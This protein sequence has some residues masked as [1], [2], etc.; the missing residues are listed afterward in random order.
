[1]PERFRVERD[2]I[3]NKGLDI[4]VLRLTGSLDSSVTDDLEQAFADGRDAGSVYFVLDFAGVEHISSAGL[5]LLLKLRK[6]AL[7]AGGRIMVARLH[8]GIREE[9]FDALGF[10][11]LIDLYATVDDAAKS[12]S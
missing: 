3:Q 5:R 9:T 2:T 12:V 6:L 1:M 4:C 7:D 11:Q 8:N 10:S